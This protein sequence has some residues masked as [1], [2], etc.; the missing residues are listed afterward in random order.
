MLPLK[1]ESENEER[2]SEK[3][4]WKKKFEIFMQWV[5][6]RTSAEWFNLNFIQTSDR[7]VDAFL[8]IQIQIQIQQTNANTNSN[9]YSYSDKDEY[10]Y[11]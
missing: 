4:K 11:N 3:V 7:R 5:H 1:S 8:P 9:T 2:K 10:K 6:P